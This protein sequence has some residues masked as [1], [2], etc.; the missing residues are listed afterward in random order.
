MKSYTTR[1]QLFLP[2]E[3]SRRL[4]YLAKNLG[5]AWS[6]IR[7]EVL[8]A[9]FNLRQ[10]PKIRRCQSMPVDAI[11]IRLTQVERN[12]GWMPRDQAMLR[13]PPTIPQPG[14]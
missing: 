2:E 8:H 1:H 3:M 4:D 12:T 10:A 14:S 11:G 6:E 9:W 7:V 13:R 5:Q